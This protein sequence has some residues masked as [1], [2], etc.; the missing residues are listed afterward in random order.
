MKHGL[1]SPR[2]KGATDRLTYKLSKDTDAYHKSPQMC[3]GFPTLPYPRPGHLSKYHSFTPLLV[4]RAFTVCSLHFTVNCVMFSGFLKSCQL[5][6]FCFSKVV[7]PKQGPFC[8]PQE[9]FY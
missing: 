1:L 4:V 3:P 8:P 2:S 9:T 5:D 7:I 6:W